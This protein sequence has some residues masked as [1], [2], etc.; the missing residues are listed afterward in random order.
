MSKGES[1][2]KTGYVHGHSNA[3]VNAHSL[4]T[5]DTSAKFLLPY[6]KPGHRVLD[7]GCG[8]G[9]ITKGFAG[10]VA[11]GQVIG[12]DSADVVI[13][14]AK[15]SALVDAELEG[16]SNLTF[17][18]A[19]MFSL[20]FEDDYFDV[21]FSHQVLYHIPLD[22]TS[23]ALKEMR[24][25]CKPGGIVAMRD[26][27][28]ELRGSQVFPPSPLLD[29]TTDIIVKRIHQDGRSYQVASYFPS[30]ARS[31]GFAPESIHR[32]FSLD[33]YDTPSTRQ[34]YAEQWAK[35]SSEDAFRRY[36]LEHDLS[37]EDEL[38]AIPGAWLAWSKTEDAWSTMI[39]LELICRK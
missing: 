15:A 9:S 35:R 3:T 37:T 4:R 10:I 32:S 14:T 19:D 6:L 29:K 36:A 22:K 2:A 34:T 12:V 16:I 24:R 38:D 21:V 11:P 5:V 31:V 7:V 39:N 1:Q 18:T 30:I 26:G 28:P 20:P 33:V 23:L 25:V 27:Q 17:Q 13:E 8:P